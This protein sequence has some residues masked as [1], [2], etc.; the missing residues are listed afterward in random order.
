MAAVTTI[1]LL[2]AS[3]IGVFA[4]EEVQQNQLKF[5]RLLRLIDG[6]YVDSVNINQI[7]EKAIVNIL[8]ELDPHSVYM[9]KDEV[10]KMNEPLVGNFEGIGITFNIFKDTLLVTTTVAGGPS[11]KVGLRAGDRIVEVDN[12]NIAG[13]GLKNS[14]VFDMLRGNKGTQ[15]NLKVLRK[16]EPGLLDFT[17]IR[18][19]IPINSLDAGYMLD[20]ATGFIKLNKFSATTTEE[21]TTAM[22]ELKKQKFQNLILDLRGNG[23]GYLN[24]AV[25][26]SGQFLD[27]NQLVVYTSGINEPRKDYN[28]GSA[29]EFKKG[30]LVILVDE[31]SASASEIVAG[32]VQDWD[33]GIIIGRRTFGKGLVQKPFYLTDGS[34][35]RLTTAHYYTP[36]GRCIQ[37][38]YDEGLD[39]YRKDYQH[40]LS[41]GEMF[42]ADSIRF[43][44]SL[45]FN[46]LIN[47]R[48]VFAGGGVMPDIFV[49]IDTSSHYGYINRLRRNNIIYNYTLDYIDKNREQIKSK[50]PQFKDFDTKFSVSDD[51]IAGIVE[52]GVKEGIEKNAE[53][54]EFSKNDMKREVKALLARD[55]YERDAFYKVYLKEDKEILKALEVIRNQKDYNSIL[56]TTHVKQ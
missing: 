28:A 53:S 24:S 49:P 5:G 54:L 51:I 50:Y 11:E 16:N 47:K 43:S 32:A 26:I 6:Y 38:P 39:E 41:S 17:I 56:V 44:D 3:A 40:R 22:K 52:N 27:N 35:V 25:E 4:Q 46:T 19:K 30:K 29:G 45:R 21:F 33:R 7:T 14:D 36:S 31:G 12:K 18:D 9:S 8:S 2:A 23:G 10:A 48:T 13:I 20:D 15:V 34:M 55:L 37:K 42:N 1:I